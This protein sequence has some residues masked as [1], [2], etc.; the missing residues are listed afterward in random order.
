MAQGA[1]MWAGLSGAE[2]SRSDCLLRFAS[3]CVRKR[4][5]YGHEAP[6][7]VFKLIWPKSG[8]SAELSW[9]YSGADMEPVGRRA[10]LPV[11]S[12]CSCAVDQDQSRLEAAGGGCHC[13]YFSLHRLA[14]GGLAVNTL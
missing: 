7:A 3:S 9:H 6:A 10:L 13:R 14:H 12:P 11:A 8:T 2:S 1:W 5:Y 4:V